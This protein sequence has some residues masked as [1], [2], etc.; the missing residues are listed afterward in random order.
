[1]KAFFGV[2]ILNSKLSPFSGNYGKIFRSG[3]SRKKSMFLDKHLYLDCFEKEKSKLGKL[4]VPISLTNFS[5]NVAGY[6]DK[7]AKN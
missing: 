2:S 3:F 6:N 7:V 4:T 1:M 5:P